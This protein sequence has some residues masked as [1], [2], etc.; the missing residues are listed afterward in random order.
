MV[1]I[2]PDMLSTTKEFYDT[3]C[4]EPK[5]KKVEKEKKKNENLSA[6]KCR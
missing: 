2:T 3:I 5:I 6:Q 1:Y 4:G